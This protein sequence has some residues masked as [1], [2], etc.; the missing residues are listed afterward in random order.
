[1]TFYQSPSFSFVNIFLYH[2]EID[3]AN[4]LEFDD[5]VLLFQLDN[6]FS[7][8]KKMAISHWKIEI[9]I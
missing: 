4:K 6:Y 1:V 2:N 8:L 5:L 7:N 9:L 3:Y